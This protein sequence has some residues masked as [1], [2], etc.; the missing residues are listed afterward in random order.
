MKFERT[1]LLSQSETFQK[2]LARLSEEKD[3]LS[4]LGAMERNALVL[5][6]QHLSQHLQQQLVENIV[7]YY[8]VQLNS[9]KPVAGKFIQYLLDK[10]TFNLRIQCFLSEVL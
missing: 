2:T 4:S 9:S 1:T 7:K 6:M 3:K 10:D 5:E 8:F